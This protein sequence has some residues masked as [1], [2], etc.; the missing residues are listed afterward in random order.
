MFKESDPW[1][2]K[3][4]WNLLLINETLVKCLMQ[5]NY[6][7]IKSFLIYLNNQLENL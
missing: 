6:T 7:Q 4:H 2:K 1:S 5:V 3:K